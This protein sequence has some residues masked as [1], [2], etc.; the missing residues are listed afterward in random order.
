[1]DDATKQT[2]PE[3]KPQPPMF[4][5]TTT[6]PEHGTASPLAPSPSELQPKKRRGRP[7]N[8]EKIVKANKT[9]RKGKPRGKRRTMPVGAAEPVATPKRRAKVP[10]QLK[11]SLGDAMSITTG[12]KEADIH[13][14]SQMADTL[15][16]VNK[17]S[18][19]KIVAA[20]GKLFG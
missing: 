9:E 18:R 15:Q 8:A 7:P 4:E 10:R 2:F 1:M 11:V 20:I 5:G 13:L 12:L 19:A 6:A 16:L 14:L 3:F 17:R